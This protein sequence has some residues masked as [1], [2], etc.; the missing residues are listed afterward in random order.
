LITPLLRREKAQ[1]TGIENTSEEKRN[2]LR[3]FRKH[4]TW[5]TGVPNDKD[6]L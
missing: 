2:W 4:D 1:E 3:T 6:A 5:F